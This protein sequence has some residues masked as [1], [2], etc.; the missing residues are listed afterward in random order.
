MFINKIRIAQKVHTKCAKLVYEKYNGLFCCL[1]VR[2][3]EPNIIDQTCTS[4]LESYFFSYEEIHIVYLK[5]QNKIYVTIL[6]FILYSI[7]VY[8]E[9]LKYKIIC[10]K[11][12]K[13][14]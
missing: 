9:S 1:N 14:N 11:T 6:L 2:D 5:K 4:L 8:L 7:C 10:L 13:S 3:F 12:P